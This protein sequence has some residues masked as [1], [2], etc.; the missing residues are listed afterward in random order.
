EVN[1][2][3]D[4]LAG[5]TGIF[6]LRD[7]VPSGDALRI[8]MPFL[9]E[10]EYPQWLWIENHQTEARNGCPTD[11][12]QYEGPGMPCVR[13]AAPGIYAQMQVDKDQRSGSNIYGGYADY[14]R[15]VLANGNFDR[16]LRG[17]TITFQCL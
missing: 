11:R 10:G 7:F 12:F 16:Q 2:D 3:L 8:R 13:P 4:P 17:D 6:V 15:P 5:D 9:P 14:L 1:G